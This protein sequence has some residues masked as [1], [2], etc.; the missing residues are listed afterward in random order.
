MTET[1]TEDQRHASGLR[2]GI[3]LGFVGLL[4]A[5]NYAGRYL[6]DAPEDE[7]SRDVLYEWSTFAGALIQFGFL[8]AVTLAL[9]WGLPARELLALRRPRSWGKSVGLAIAVFVGVYVVAG[10]V[11]A[12]GADPGEEQ[13][14]TPEGWDASRAAPFLANAVVVALFVPVVEELQFRG[15]GFSLLAPYGTTLA[16]VVTG[17]LFALGHGVVYG[18]PIFLFMGFG[19]AFIRHRMDSIYPTIL[20]HACFN[21]L[22]LVV[23]VTA[24]GDS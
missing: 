16:I 11:G 12:F 19:L 24:G 22:A 7:N 18:L 2:L 15:L 6:V 5:L 9:T 14:L 21:A 1:R 17:L 23:A 3:W 4:I 20:M 8:L 13:G 10:I